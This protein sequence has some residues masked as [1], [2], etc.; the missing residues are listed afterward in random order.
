MEIEEPHAV[1]VLGQ[2]LRHRAAHRFRGAV[3]EGESKDPLGL[4]P[5]GDR[6]RNGGSGGARL[7]GAHG[8]EHEERL[9]DRLDHRLLLVV[10][11]HAAS[12]LLLLGRLKPESDQLWQWSDSSRR[13][14][15]IG[16]SE[17]VERRCRKA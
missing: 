16:M 5:V 15:W 1:A 17:A 12:M 3:R 14:S 13:G 2:D 7:A 8:R 4:D 6:T 10:R 9:A 11:E